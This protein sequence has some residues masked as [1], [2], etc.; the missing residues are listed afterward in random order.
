MSSESGQATVEWVGLVLLVA[1][2]ISGLGALVGFA[3]PGTELLSA[4][5]SKL[6]CAARLGPACGSQES[7]L[8]AAYGEQGAAM[9][10]AHAPQIRYEHGMHALPVDYRSRREDAC[11]NGAEGRVRVARSVTGEPTVAFTH[12]VDCRPGSET[13]GANC[14][15]EAAGNQYVQYWLYYPGSATG[16]GS[17]A[18]G[19]IR[20]L[21]GGA[22]YH[23]D[24]RES[25][26]VRV[27]ADGTADV[28]A[29][30][31]HDYGSGWRPADDSVYRVSGGSHA[32]TIEPADFARVTP[33][34]RL[35]LIPLEPIAADRPGAEFAITPPWFKRVWLDPEYGGT[36]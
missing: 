7:D 19:V 27:H 25:V 8:V 16:E 18:P 26:Q 31:H 10:A 17:V 6:V 1:L 12:M 34:R 9:V 35:G 5:A 33:A 21:T 4:V 14:S 22:T 24:D 32:G 11:A 13:P 20:E 28:R 36:D 23:P 15:G 29:S 30:S 2:V 3:I